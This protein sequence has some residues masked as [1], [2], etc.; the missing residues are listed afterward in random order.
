MTK[1]RFSSVYD[2]HVTKG[3]KFTKPSKTKQASKDECDVNRIVKRFN[4]TGH[5]SHVRNGQPLY[6]D[7]DTVETFH[8]AMNIVTNA[9]EQ[10]ALLPAEI[11]KR[12]AN[13]PASFLQ[14]VGDPANADELVKM[15]LATKR[16]T[17]APAVPPAPKAPLP[18]ET[19]KNEPQG[20]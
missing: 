1:K 4:E 13:D 2:H 19:P 5:V 6:G 16:E 7:F 10:F 3:I 17:P 11:R 20:S 14:F 15:G 12:F 8:E 18:P 9:Q